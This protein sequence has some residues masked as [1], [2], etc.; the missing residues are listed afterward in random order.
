LQ[1]P[2]LVEIDATGQTVIEESP[3]PPIRRLAGH[4]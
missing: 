1:L 2:R 4:T 3:V